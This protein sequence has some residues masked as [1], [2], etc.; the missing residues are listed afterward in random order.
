MRNEKTHDLAYQHFCVNKIKAKY[1]LC[2][3][4]FSL[5]RSK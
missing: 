4:N 1:F 3:N 2:V 5:L